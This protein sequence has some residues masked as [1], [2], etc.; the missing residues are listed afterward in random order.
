M[1]TPFPCATTP[2]ET[3]PNMSSDLNERPTTSHKNNTGLESQIQP[4]YRTPKHHP[5]RPQQTQACAVHPSSSSPQKPQL[6][7]ASFLTQTNN[8]TPPHHLSPQGLGLAKDRKHSGP[9]ATRKGEGRSGGEL[10]NNGLVLLLT[11]L[12]H[13]DAVSSGGVSD[14][15]LLES[16][17]T[18]DRFVQMAGMSCNDEV[19]GE[20]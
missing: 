12:R 2:G 4:H 6:C 16:G 19:P 13:G 9:S 20:N 5:S 11:G 8:P 14:V 17:L 10:R 7:R 1:I 3:F 15:R 18:S